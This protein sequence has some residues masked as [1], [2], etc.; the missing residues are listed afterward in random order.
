M[1][2]LFVIACCLGL[3]SFAGAAQEQRDNPR[4]KKKGHNVQSSEQAATAGAHV[5]GKGKLQTHQNVS[6][7]PSRTTS[8]TQ[9]NVSGSRTFRPR[10][11]DLATSKPKKDIPNVKFRAGNRIQGSQNWQGSNYTA[12]R[13]YRSQW[14]DRAWWRHHHDRII[15]VFGGWYFWDAGYWYPAWGYDPYA[16]Y[17]YDGP[18]YAYNDLPPDQVVANVQAS[19]QAQGYYHGEVDGLL[20]PLTRAAL[21]DY[22]RD[23]GLYVTSAIDQP[24]LASLGMV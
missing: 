13:N 22:Q 2:I 9:T 8:Q 3:A 12:F 1:R 23:R 21:A 4:S 11:F 6:R 7:A 20:G 15:F 18:I 5:S 17:A 16:F 19:L 24:T 10:H 14:H